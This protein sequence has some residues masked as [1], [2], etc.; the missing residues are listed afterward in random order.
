M[1]I[2]IISDSHGNT[3]RVRQA[4]YEMG[5]VDMLFH[6][7][8]GFRDV[9][10]IGAYHDGP[11]VGVRGNQDFGSDLPPTVILQLDGY[12]VLLTH[13]HLH[14]VKW[15][16]ERLSFSAREQQVRIV[17]Y[18]HTHQSA[19]EEDR[20]ILYVNPGSLLGPNPGYAV[21]RII[22]NQII[23]ALH[24]LKGVVRPRE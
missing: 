13:G 10:D 18:G 16:M 5:R 1:R 3:G 24:P 4:L 23:P 9:Q 12:R 2:G 15:G 22:K 14:R 17:C 8:D 21:I 19:C 11:V 20:G 6:L 7:G